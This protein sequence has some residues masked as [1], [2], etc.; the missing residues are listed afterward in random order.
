MIVADFR[1][2]K[3]YLKYLAEV[4]SYRKTLSLHNVRIFM[5]L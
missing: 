3:K 1:I 4:D 2:Q 5:M